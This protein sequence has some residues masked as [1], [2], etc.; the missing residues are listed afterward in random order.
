VWG[1]R[2]PAPVIGS[3]QVVKIVAHEFRPRDLVGGHVV[4]DLLNTVTART[5]I[6]S[7][8][9]WVRTPAGVGRVERA[10]RSKRPARAQASERGP[11][12]SGFGGLRSHAL[13]PE[14]YCTRC[15]SAIAGATGR[16]RRLFDISRCDGRRPLR[17]LGQEQPGGH[18]RLALDIE[19]CSLDHLNDELAFARSTWSRT[20]PPIARGCARD[21]RAVGCS[22][23]DRRA[24]GVGGATWQRAATSPKAGG[25]TN[26]RGPGRTPEREP[27][28]TGRRIV[29]SFLGNDR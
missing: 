8:G 4:V 1:P 13:A 28:R 9:S 27:H 6:P 11:P 26:A 7:T 14:K 23:I 16:P 5:P 3:S 15:L 17:T 18:V 24:S 29:S 12:T 2:W 20:C 19:G 22:S 21:L 25:I 10:V